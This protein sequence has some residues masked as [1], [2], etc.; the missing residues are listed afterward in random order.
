V[1][2]RLQ[3][4]RPSNVNRYLQI[5]LTEYQTALDEGAI[6]SVSEGRIRVRKLPI[7]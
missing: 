4:M 5:L 3:N 1:I 6:F 7:E 2:F